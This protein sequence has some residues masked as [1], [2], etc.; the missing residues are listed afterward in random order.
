MTDYLVKTLSERRWETYKKLSQE[1]NLPPDELYARNLA[2]SKELYVILSGLEVVIRN[3]FH[4][5]LKARY[6]REDWLSKTDIF[7]RSHKE[8]IDKA[9]DKL[10]QNRKGNY[11]LDDLIAELSLGFWTHLVDSPYEKEFWIPA[12]RHSFPHKFGSPVRKDV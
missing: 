9:T 6:G 12:L 2:Y 11:T 3:A 8:Q 7:R 4:E 1:A 10:G 5:Q